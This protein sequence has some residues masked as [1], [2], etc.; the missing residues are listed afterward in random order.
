MTFLVAVFGVLIA[1][2]G[3]VGVAAPQK[4]IA[5]VQKVWTPHPGLYLAISLRLLLGV[6]LLVAAPESAAPRALWVLG[7]L[8]VAAAVAIPCLG[9]SRTL[10]F[11]GWWTHRPPALI[12]AWSLAALVFGG[13]LVTA[14]TRAVPIVP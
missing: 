12:R 14:V 11:I 5:I 4:L 7:W 10:R 9:F 1:M 3:L 8:A 2:L 6:A 13:F